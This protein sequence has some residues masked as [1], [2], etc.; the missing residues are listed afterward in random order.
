MKLLHSLSFII[1]LC[2]TPVLT[3]A[4]INVAG[5][6]AGV[7]RVI[8]T[9]KQPIWM[10]GFAVRTHP[11]DGTLH[12]LWAKAL[13]LEDETGKQAVFVTTDL[14][15]FPKKLSDRIRDRLKT[16]FGL[17]KA[18]IILNSS[19]TH[20]GPVLSDALLDIYPIDAEQ[21]AK[22]EQYTATLENQ[23]VTLVGDALRSKEPVTLSAQQGV[24]RFQVNR[25]NNNA[26][27]LHRL[28]ELQGP[29]DY[30]VPVIKVEK[31]N[32]TLKA[33]LFGY[34]CHPT[35]LDIYRWSGDYVGFAQLELEKAHP[36][37][38]ALFFQCAG[39]DQNALPR[40]TIP[41]AQQYGRELA[42][43]VERVL[44]EPMRT[45]SPQLSTAY[46][47]V[48]LAFAKSPTETDLLAVTKSDVPYYKRWA[49]RML[50]KLRQGES[51]M[52]SYA[53]PVQVWQLGNQ[54][55]IS[56]G[57]EVVVEYSIKLKQIFGPDTFIAG[58]SNDVMGYIP[59]TT[60][61]RE[62]GY[63]GDT[64]QMV[65]GLPGVWASTIETTILNE[66]VKVARQAGVKT[67]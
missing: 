12:D 26:T 61:L 38:T 60:V 3:K 24:T 37:V 14:L 34:S 66:V 46:S 52:T 59:S 40:H 9:P 51:F 16:S 44:A 7:S 17:S 10:A 45:L 57:G 42:S 31:A 30:A 63:E 35:V 43:A 23:I 47:E 33:V 56:L 27:L 11:A 62:G 32:G 50:A 67:P 6:K 18:Q 22:V 41:L 36:D 64:A 25:R 28:P 19:H 58:Y 55:I 1:W 39:A 29:N 15:G 13:A 20:S 5:W 4:D 2:L 48:D 8:I 49:E 21:L 53:Y 65:Y 54:P